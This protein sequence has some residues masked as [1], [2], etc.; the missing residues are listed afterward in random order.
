M[1]TRNPRWASYPTA[2]QVDECA[3]VFTSAARAA[4]EDDFTAAHE[5]VQNYLGTSNDEAADRIT[6]LIGIGVYECAELMRGQLGGVGGGFYGLVAP[7]DGDPNATAVFRT[8]TAY[9]NADYEAA[10]DV[11]DVHFEAYGDV[12]N[13]ELLAQLTALY[14]ASLAVA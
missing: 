6:W 7:P 11:L 2:E 12:G 1:T 9:L 4:A 14:N 3:N 13:G 8:I 5:I 10:L